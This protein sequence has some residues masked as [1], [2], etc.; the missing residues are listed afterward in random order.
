MDSL[1]LTLSVP[2]AAAALGCDRTTLYRLAKQSPDPLP[3]RKMGGRAFFLR[4]E[5]E[6]WV[7][8]R[9]MGAVTSVS[10]AA[11]AGR[12]SKRKARAA[13]GAQ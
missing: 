10:D 1:R 9:P 6:A 12:Q 11:I 13:G 8:A 5:L 2:E 3:L 4:D 7:K